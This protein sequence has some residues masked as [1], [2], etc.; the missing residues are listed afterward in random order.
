MVPALRNF[1][2]HADSCDNSV[3]Y[4]RRDADPSAD[5]N[6]AAD[7]DANRNSAAH[8]Y[9]RGDADE[10]APDL[11]DDLR[12]A[13][14]A[15][16]IPRG[17]RTPSAKLLGERLRKLKGRVIGGRRIVAVQKHN[18]VSAWDVETV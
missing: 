17:Q 15:I 1:P 3:S 4:S 13:L 5:Q 8:R 2:Q 12:D 14:E 11:W 10:L 18:H 9:A 16:A 6:S 7:I